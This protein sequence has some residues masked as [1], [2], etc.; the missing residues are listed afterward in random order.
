MIETT[1]GKMGNKNSVGGPTPFP[2]YLTNA[3]TT[4]KLTPSF[5]PT[6]L[7]TVA[8]H[9]SRPQNFS[10]ILTITTL[11]IIGGISIVLLLSL[12]SSLVGWCCEYDRDAYDKIEEIDAIADDH[13]RSDAESCAVPTHV[14]MEDRLKRVE[15]KLNEAFARMEM[16]SRKR[17]AK[18]QELEM[19]RQELQTTKKGFAQLSEEVDMLK[20]TKLDTHGIRGGKSFSPIVVKD[21]EQRKA[22]TTEKQRHRYTIFSVSSPPSSSSTNVSD[23][24]VDGGI[25]RANIHRDRLIPNNAFVP[26][27]DL[28]PITEPISRRTSTSSSSAR[29]KSLRRGTLEHPDGTYEG[30]I[31]NGAANG[32]GTK[33]YSGDWKGQIYEGKWKDNKSHGYG[34]FQWP[35]G[36]RFSQYQWRT[37]RFLSP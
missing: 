22:Q 10:Q 16:E 19:M 29:T 20:N 23:A 4:G 14:D 30:E 21:E 34:I 17:E 15:G 8:N 25:V 13:A 12:V 36:S 18:E 3:P 26:V 32:Y 6:A 31:L 7:P 28:T 2:T 9:S 33:R 5:Q 11:W 24:D 35:S 37:F 27:G 1:S